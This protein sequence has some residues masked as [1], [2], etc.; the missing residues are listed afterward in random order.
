MSER[1][2]KKSRNSEMVKRDGTERTVEREGEI[3]K[4]CVEKRGRKRK[5]E[6]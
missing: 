5:I 6:K 2:G 3:E 4:I 1:K